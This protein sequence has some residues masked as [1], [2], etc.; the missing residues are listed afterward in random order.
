MRVLPGF[1]GALNSGLPD[2]LIAILMLSPLVCI[3]GARMPGG[4]AWSGF[5]VLPMV[6][7]LSWPVLSQSWNMRGTEAIQTGTPAA[8]GF[9]LV[10]LM[11]Y[12]NYFGTANTL[13]ATLYAS[14]ILCRMWPSA[15]WSTAGPPLFV[16]ETLP[17]LA[18]LMLH[19]RIHC[20]GQWPVK[21]RLQSANRLWV[22]FR[23][24]FG[25]VWAKRVMD[26]MNLFSVRESWRVS[27]SLDGFVLAEPFEFER[28]I[29]PNGSLT[30]LTEDP[31]SG[32]PSLISNQP[33]STE[34][35]GILS[36]NATESITDEQIERPLYVLCWLL[37]R[38]ADECWRQQRLGIYYCAA[39]R[40]I[41]EI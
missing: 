33:E 38:F 6:V 19:H 10:L 41:P 37:S 15:G 2:Y 12:G 8:L 1:N 28:S 18:G 20:L 7:V 26:R 14:A 9:V 4:R 24:L 30:G 5:V 16:T 22:T 17:V 34:A 25:I 31:S 40:T 32:S 36:V 35:S 13:S 21:S 3:L 39:E 23:D 11:G 29:A 27:L